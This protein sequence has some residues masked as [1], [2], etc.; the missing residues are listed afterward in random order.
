MKEAIKNFEKY[1]QDISRS[2]KTYAEL[3]CGHQYLLVKSETE[4]E[5]ILD[6]C[7]DIYCGEVAEK[8]YRLNIFGRLVEKHSYRLN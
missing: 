6:G 4:Y 1:I 2:G 3:F 7:L 8:I 5:I